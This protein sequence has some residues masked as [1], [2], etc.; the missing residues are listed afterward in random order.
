MMARFLVDPPHREGGQAQFIEHLPPEGDPDITEVITWVL[1][2]LD[3]QLTLEWIGHHSHMSAWTMRHRFHA[4]TAAAGSDFRYPAS[5]RAGRAR[6]PPDP[7]P[8]CD[9]HHTRKGELQASSRIPLLS[10]IPAG[11]RARRLPFHTFPHTGV[12]AP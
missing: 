2:H 8:A 3:E 10:D 5:G 4:A 1:E 12:E 6:A 9:A 11:R 7:Q